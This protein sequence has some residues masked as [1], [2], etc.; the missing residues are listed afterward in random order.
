MFRVFR[1]TFLCFAYFTSQ[2]ARV[3]WFDSTVLRFADSH[4][5]RWSHHEKASLYF[6][7]VEYELALFYWCTLIFV[8]K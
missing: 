4:H 8:N 1:A 3:Q 7:Q 5:E 2:V 6:A